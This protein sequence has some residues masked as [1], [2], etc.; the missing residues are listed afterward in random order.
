MVATQFT[1]L[2]LENQASQI[3]DRFDF[4]KVLAHMQATDHKWF[5]GGDMRVP[6]MM[7][8]RF[9]ARSLL[10]KAIYSND[11]VT[12]VGSG[13]F[14]AY[15]LPWGLQLTFQLTWSSAF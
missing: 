10:V 11:E 5:L 8:L 14:V 15:K 9:H 1:A 2:E 12:N 13:G 4:D 6:D 3:M 7:D